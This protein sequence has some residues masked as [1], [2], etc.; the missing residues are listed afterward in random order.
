MVS[1]LVIYGTLIYNIPGYTAVVHPDQEPR[2]THTGE[3]CT[4]NI[5]QSRL[6]IFI[7]SNKKCVLVFTALIG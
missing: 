7:A 2:N 4:D 3:Y 5:T 1:P 6:H